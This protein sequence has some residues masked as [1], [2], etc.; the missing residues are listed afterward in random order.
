MNLMQGI[1]IPPCKSNVQVDSGT[2]SGYQTNRQ[3]GTIELFSKS[4]LSDTKLDHPKQM[5][6]KF[7]NLSSLA[8][9]WLYIRSQGDAKL[10]GFPTI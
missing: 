4:S 10:L 1:R 7:I 8:L 9:H 2:I 5:C 3:N 6:A